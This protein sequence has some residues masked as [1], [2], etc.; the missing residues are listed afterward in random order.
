MYSSLGS[1]YEF[2]EGGI[3]SWRGIDG[4]GSDP[5]VVFAGIDHLPHL[6]VELVALS[7]E[8]SIWKSVYAFERKGSYFLVDWRVVAMEGMCE[9][10]ID[11]HG[12][13]N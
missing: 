3:S 5:K 10:A 11:V 7:D 8:L 2:N 4:V 13:Y 6:L 9:D 1:F 12:Y